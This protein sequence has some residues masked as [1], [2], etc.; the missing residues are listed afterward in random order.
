MIDGGVVKCW[1]DWV[2]GAIAQELFNGEDVG[3]E[4]NEMPPPDVNVGGA[5]ASIQS[6]LLCGTT[7]R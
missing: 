7:A 1:G 2:Y 5:V 6:G 4:P 3:D